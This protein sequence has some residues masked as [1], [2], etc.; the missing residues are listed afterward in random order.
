MTTRSRKTNNP[1]EVRALRAEVAA[2]HRSQAVIRFA[3]DG[4]VVSANENF[5]AA[6]GYTEDEI[7]GRHHRT[8]VTAEHA[9]SPEYR[10]FWDRLRAG[11]F[12]SEEFERVGKAGNTVW[13]QASYN[14]ILGPDGKPEAVVKYATDITES[15]LR[16]ADRKGR[17]AAIDR[18][19]AVIAFEPDGTILEANANFLGAVG[20]ELEEIV[21]QHHRMF[22]DP[23]ESSRPEYAQFWRDLA[24]GK[25]TSGEFRRVGK[26]GKEVWIQASYNPILDPSGKVYKVVKYATDITE[27][28]LRAAQNERFASV[29]QNTQ[30][31][32][33]SCDP[34]FNIRYMNPG[35]K[36]LFTEYREDLAALFP[37][38]DPENLIGTSIDIFHKDPRHQRSLLSD[39]SRLPFETELKVGRL[40][41]GLRAYELR[42]A[43]GE[44]VG[45]NTEWADLSERAEFGRELQKVVG[46]LREGDLGQRCDKSHLTGEYA[47]MADG[48]NELIEAVAAPVGSASRAAQQLARGADPRLRRGELGGELGALIDSM[49]DL[50]RASN[51]ISATVRSVAGGDLTVDVSPRSAEDELLQSLSSMV[52]SLSQTLTEISRAST[53][54]N[55]GS[56]QVATASQ[57]VSD[58]STQSAASIEEVSASSERIA[59]QTRANAENA[60]RALELADTAR[61]R[62]EGG[63]RVMKSMLE[64]MSEIQRMG[65]DISKIVKVIDEIAFQTNLLALN[66]AVEAGRAGE[67]GK[68]FAVVAEEVGRLAA[69]SATAARETTE[70]IEETI[71]KV[72]GGMKLAEE[73]ASSLTQIVDGVTEVRQLVSEI[74]DSS[75]EQA[76]GIGE[77]NI[78]LSQV[79]AV[80]QRNTA[81]AEEMAAAANELSA[82]SERMSELLAAFRLRTASAATPDGMSPELM[83]MFQQFLASQGMLTQPTGAHSSPPPRPERAHGSSGY[84][85]GN[86]HGGN[87]HGSSLDLVDS[88]FGRY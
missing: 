12:F 53:E 69:R 46:A 61:T 9:A 10:A 51:E 57:S 65:K 54:V 86:G 67:H 70:I 28:K 14:P 41:V 30:L 68:G 84:S 39:P 26:G 18:V 16:Q 77:I 80:T 62:A 36:R 71:L 59:S 6:L 8:F 63:D 78:G 7:V 55:G 1:D 88:E 23:A 29:L 37:G 47:R 81:D 42:N 4:T 19:Q 34:E 43:Q 87:G 85:N 50:A 75:R 73:T 15:K 5:C 3:M 52:E 76:D 13:I 32:T 48:I 56:S 38:F 22:V 40:Q 45:Y 11:E 17:L 25:A 79:D 66:A 82:Q 21:G 83:N 2:L 20:Y 72:S 64:A 33:M 49:C 58:N 27:A 60:G 31:A 35:V 24:N 74:A 44:V